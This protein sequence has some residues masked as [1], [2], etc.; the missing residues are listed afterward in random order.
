MQGLFSV[1]NI[2][3]GSFVLGACFLN[4]NLIDLPLP[5]IFCIFIQIYANQ[6]FALWSARQRYEYKYRSL[7]AMTFI[8]AV[9]VTVFSVL[10]VS[11]FPYESMKA[12]AKVFHRLLADL[13]LQ[14][15][16]LLVHRESV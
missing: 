6:I 8:F 4:P 13:S 15:V 2:I 12:S 14:L 1:V 11:A 9:A 3:V 16:L 7:L 10:V 5:F